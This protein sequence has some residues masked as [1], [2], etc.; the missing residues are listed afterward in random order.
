MGWQDSPIVGQQAQPKWASSPIVQDA[1]PRP[2]QQ[3]TSGYSGNLGPDLLR[4][5]GRAGR[6]VAAG[7]GS[8]ADIALLAPKTLASAAEYGLEKT[9]FEGSAPERFAQKIRST[10]TMRESVQGIIDNATGGT[11]KP[12]GN[13]EKVADFASEMVAPLGM[14]TKAAT[15]NPGMIDAVRGVLNPAEPIAQAAAQKYATPAINLGKQAVEKKTSEQIRKQA[16]NSYKEADELGGILKPEV[17]NKFVDDLD[18]MLPQTEKGRVLQGGDNPVA[19]VIERMKSFRDQPMT[20]QEA[21]ELDELLADQITYDLGKM[22]KE[23]KKIFDIQTSLREALAGA[24]DADTI[25][26]RAGFDA[27]K[28]GQKLWSQSL[29]MRDIE[30]IMERAEM[31]DVPATGIKTGFRTL[32]TNPNRM[33]GFSKPEQEAIRKAAETGI[34]TD[35]L[36]VFGSRLIPIAGSAAGYGAG[37]PLGSLATGAATYGLSTASRNAATKMQTSKAQKVADLVAGTVTPQQLSPGLTSTKEA[38]ARTMANILAR[39]GQQ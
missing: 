37:G 36:K 39:M 38:T 30:R 34:A 10:P 32:A 35:L 29:K 2:A 24:T 20:L 11:L 6:N 22:T 28:K 31:M 26:G 33:R 5:A 3:P 9:G 1:Q 21:Q 16:S 19:T 12:V 15:P 7:I 18:K 13:M 23:G 4:T 25:G 27:W 17:T 8:L 14:S